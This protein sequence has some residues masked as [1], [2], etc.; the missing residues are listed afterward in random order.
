MNLKLLSDELMLTG[1]IT[2]VL[3]L[4]F[5]IKDK[6][7]IIAYTFLA[8]IAGLTLFIGLH[9]Q[10]GV[11]LNGSFIYDGISWFSKLIIMLG[12]VLATVMSL[13][14]IKVKPKY[15]G[16]YYALMG[17]SA[18]GMMFLVSSKE[19]VTLYVALE[20]ATISLIVLS[21]M[22]KHD[23]LSLEAGMKYLLLGALSSGILLYGLS[24]VYAS[25]KTTYLD[26][27]MAVVSS[28]AAGPAFIL[29]IILVLLGVGFK[30]SMVPMHVWTP[31]VYQGAPTPVAAYISVASKAAGFIFAIRLF[32]YTFLKLD[33]V[34]VPILMVLAVL[35][36]MI[37]NLVAISQK[38]LKR[39]LAYSTISQAGYIL[40]G[41]VGASVIGI[42]SVL[43]YLF[44]Y[45]LTN[46]LAF[47]VL[48]VVAKNT[49]S[50]E[51]A[52]Y[53]GLARREPFLAVSLMLAL[54]SLA[55]IPPLAGF[56]GK[57]YLFYAAMEK[58]YVWLVI[59]AALNSTLSLY[60]YLLVLRQMYIYDSAVEMPKMKIPVS[61]RILIIVC[62]IAILAV[63]IM[64]GWFIDTTTE[65]AQN[66]FTYTK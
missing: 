1:I 33:Y 41:F 39:L 63:G 64:P 47:T 3:L 65:I 42:S 18:L 43:F 62:I 25:A 4:D 50:D 8:L 28:G 15:T 30:L 57:F 48:A 13:E 55:G 11:V 19:L 12:A 29:G 54:L 51:L 27:I 40:V 2:A 31:D 24:L 20:L 34:W 46:I 53:S 22:H 21:A 9:R 49:G 38:N 36:M 23:D 37:G 26:R 5:I 61:L 58:G 6:K 59:I 45:T 52:D 60:Y 10:Q 14:T 66:M 7:Q 56:V 16:A 44:A 17:T 35:T 32:Q